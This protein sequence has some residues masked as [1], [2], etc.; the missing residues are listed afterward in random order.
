[1]YKRQIHIS[2]LAQAHVS[3]LN[4]ILDSDLKSHEAINI[5]TGAGVTVKEI[6]SCFEDVNSVKL[7]FKVSKRRAGDIEASIASPRKA[8]QILGWSSSYSLEDMCVS[9]FNFYKKHPNAINLKC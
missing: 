6:I 9:A 2:D 8:K 5:G 7:K 4:F 3:A 1:M